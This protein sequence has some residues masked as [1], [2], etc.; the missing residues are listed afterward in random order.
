MG[1]RG[2]FKKN[3]VRCYMSN[4]VRGWDLFVVVDEVDNNDDSV[5]V[6]Y[7]RMRY[8][9]GC[10]KIGEDRSTTKYFISESE[11]NVIKYKCTRYYLCDD[12][13]KCDADNILERIC[14]E[15]FLQVD[16]YQY[17]Y[18]IHKINSR[19]NQDIW[20]GNV[21]VSEINNLDILFLN[22]FE[23]RQPLFKKCC[24]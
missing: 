14:E 18:K 12:Y 8:V 7:P 4:R 2:I 13:C 24:T 23:I 6:I 15:N 5:N 17:K 19:K 9:D 10:L 20:Y 1:K 11:Y 3:M 16:T 21:P 22:K